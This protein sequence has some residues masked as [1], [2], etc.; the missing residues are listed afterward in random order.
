MVFIFSNFIIWHALTIW[1]SC[2]YDLFRYNWIQVLL[3]I[4][5]IFSSNGVS[6]LEISNRSWCFFQ[7]LLWIWSRINSCS[8]LFVTFCTLLEWTG[9][10][11]VKPG[12][13]SLRSQH[14]HRNVRWFVILANFWVS[15]SNCF[16]WYIVSGPYQLD[17]SCL[18]FWD[19]ACWF[20]LL[21]VFGL[22][23]SFY[24][25][26]HNISAD[27]S[28]SLLQVFVKLGNLHGTS[29]YVLYWIHRGRLLWFH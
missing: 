8:N 1:N 9:I 14:L 11:I 28:S 23:S 18:N 24:C 25:Y 3:S 22:L 16:H 20:L 7:R 19:K 21:R 10:F 5:D 13:T 17:I 26:F 6:L 29:N 15:F 27:M 12:G 4:I 2:S